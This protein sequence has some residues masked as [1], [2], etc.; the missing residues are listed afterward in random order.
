MSERTTETD[1]A[2]SREAIHARTERVIPRGFFYKPREGAASRDTFQLAPLIVQEISNGAADL[3]EDDRIAG[4]VLDANGHLSFH[5]DRPAVYVDVS[6]VQLNGQDHDQLSYTWFYPLR[7]GHDYITWRCCRMTLDG[8]GLPIIWEVLG[9]QS[10]P[11]AL[12]VSK[13]LELG[14]AAAFGPPLTGRR[15]SI[16]TDMNSRSDVRV[17]RILDDGP[18]P[19]GPFVY[20]TA[21]DL[22]VMT[23]TCRCMPS[24]VRDLPHSA[25]YELRPLSELRKITT[26]LDPVRL[27]RVLR[28]PASF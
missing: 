3:P 14:A 16:E 18:R 20:L 6:I 5:T 24:Q 27:D 10:G 22:E 4:L 17:A 13:S 12:Y 23:L 7:T 2:P 1:W 9:S 28:L 11:D 19:M 15:F 21:E 25:Y 8:E 26:R